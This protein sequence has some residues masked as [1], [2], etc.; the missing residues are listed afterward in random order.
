[1]KDRL[2]SAPTTSKSFKLKFMILESKKNHF[3]NN[4]DWACQIIRYIRYTYQLSLLG[5]S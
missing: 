2:T 4:Y 5:S 1:M 3:K